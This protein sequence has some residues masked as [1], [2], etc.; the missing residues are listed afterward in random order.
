[1]PLRVRLNDP[2]D[3][4]KTITVEHWLGK[5]PATQGKGRPASTTKPTTLAGDGERKTVVLTRGNEKNLA[6]GELTLAGAEGKTMWIQL[7][8]T[9]KSGADAWNSGFAYVPPPAVERKGITLVNKQSP[10]SRLV[11]FTIK[12]DSRISTAF[13]GQAQVSGHTFVQVAEK[14]QLVG[15][16]GKSS[17]RLE[18]KRYGRGGGGPL[19]SSEKWFK[20]HPQD[21]TGEFQLDKESNVEINRP[22]FD[23]APPNVQQELGNIIGNTQKWLETSTIPIPTAPLACG[24]T[25]KGKRPLQ[26]VNNEQATLEMS[27]TYVGTRDRNGRKEA[28]VLLEGTILPQPFRQTDKGTL[29]GAALVDLATGQVVLERALIELSVDT[30]FGNQPAHLVGTTELQMKR[31]LEG[32]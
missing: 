22:F 27:Y 32:K 14:A 2:L 16:D 12:S 5:A 6:S 29:N 18:Y 28:V 10:P 24:D 26:L 4:I 8:H 1:M 7:H 21:I 19:T 9:S 13:G 30:N 3:S 11:D 31:T 25:W 15:D 23:K 17:V 20:L